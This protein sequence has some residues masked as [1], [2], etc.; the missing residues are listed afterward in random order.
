MKKEERVLKT[1]PFCGSYARL[2]ED[3][4]FQNQPHEFPKWFIE[5][6]KCKVRTITSTMRYVVDSWNRRAKTIEELN[7]EDD[8]K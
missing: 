7:M 8:G 3:L 4:R 5:C 6:G 2:Y 1:C